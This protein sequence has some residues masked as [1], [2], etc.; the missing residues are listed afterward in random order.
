MRK[1][2]LLIIIGFLSSKVHS[3]Q[4]GTEVLSFSNNC[5]NLANPAGGVVINTTLPFT[6][7]WYMATVIFE[8][9]NYGTGET[10]GLTISWHPWI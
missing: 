10:I 8:G 7:N 9:F 4:I 3:Q 5:A 2:L 6:G 1:I